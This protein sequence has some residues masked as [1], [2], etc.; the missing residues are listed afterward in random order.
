MLRIQPSTG[1]DFDRKNSDTLYQLYHAIVD[2]P[3]FDLT[4]EKRATLK[5]ACTKEIDFEA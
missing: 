1:N 4:D 5:N 3:V 2:S